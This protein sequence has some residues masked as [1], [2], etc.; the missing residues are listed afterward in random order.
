MNGLSFYWYKAPWVLVYMLQQV[1]YRPLKF[2]SWVSTI[3][4][5]RLVQR[6][7][8]LVPT[9]AARGL[10]VISYMSW[11]APMVGGLIGAV[12]IHNLLP[13]VGV[14]CAPLLCVAMLL[15]GTAI[16][17]PLVID[18]QQAKEIATAR[19]TLQALPAQRIAV[20]GSYGKTTMKE[21]LR[22]VLAEGKRIAVTPGNRNVLISHARWINS[23]LDAD[24]DII[25]F[26]Y[27]EA[28]PGDIARLASLSQ[29]TDAVITGL[30][31]AHLDGYE[32][33]DAI[34]KDFITIT[35]YVQPDHLYINAESSGLQD[36][37]GLNY[38]SKGIGDIRISDVVMSMTGMTFTVTHGQRTLKLTT[39]LIGEHQLGPLSAVIDLAIKCGL[40]DTQITTGVSQ[41]KPFEHRMQPR[42]VAGGWIID[43][44]YNGNIEGMRAG[45]RLLADMPAQRKFYITPGLVDQGREVEPVH[46]SLGELIAAASPDTVVL[47][48]NSVTGFIQTGLKNGNY[49]GEVII[50]DNPLDFYTNIEHFIAA[51]DLLLMQNDWPDNYL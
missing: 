26:E 24:A 44:T 7:G 16:V 46:V 9:T 33:V 1:E 12:A 25:V 11:L 31:P 21:L 23:Q 45:L 42:P 18:R 29:P 2:M 28:A 38:S 5:L 43:D 39:G 35:D 3:P 51:G 20:L 4:D 22:T 17:K 15:L 10:L 47:M 34:V 27:G 6:R 32:S 13:L 8:Q 49:H 30:A 41:T 50:Q 37:Q 36:V 19:R 48:K 14:C 40:S